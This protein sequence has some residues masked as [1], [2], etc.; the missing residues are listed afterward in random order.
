[1]GFINDLSSA[2]LYE[3][4]DSD[5]E[6]VHRIQRD[7]ASKLRDYHRILCA[8]FQSL[9]CV[10]DK[11]GFHFDLHYKK[12]IHH[13]VMKPI[14]G[15]IIGDNEG[16]DKI[17]ARYQMYSKC[18]RLCRCCDI[19][20]ENSDNTSF[21]FVYTKQSDIMNLLQKCDMKESTAALNQISY[22]ILQSSKSR[23]A[24]CIN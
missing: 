12:Q 7:S 14:I 20:F 17:V 6:T 4:V 1:M 16:Q 13:L 19:S 10:Q 24:S 22:L 11:G 9:K 18:N 21:P 15:P 2:K 23:K 5:G 3:E 8:I